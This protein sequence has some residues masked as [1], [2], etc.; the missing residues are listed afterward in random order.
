MMFLSAEKFS[1]AKKYE[2]SMSNWG[3]KGKIKKVVD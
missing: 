2:N 1:I 3:G